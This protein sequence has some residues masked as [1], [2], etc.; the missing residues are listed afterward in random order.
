MRHGVE[1]SLEPVRLALLADAETE[2]AQIIG[3]A[4]RDAEEFEVKAARECDA[5]VAKA[6]R[7]SELA[8]EAHAERVL[9]R[10]RNGSRAVVLQEQEKLRRQLIEQVRAAALDARGDPHYPALLDRWEAMAREQLGS[11]VVIERDPD[12]NG[13]VIAV[14]GSR[15]VD[16]T[17]PALADRAL[18][19]IADEVT[20]LWT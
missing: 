6:R 1:R 11:A 14:A 17:L 8:G 20:Q 12:P 9:A 15:R 10:A 4:R 3:E 13:G 2:A 19:R 18:D 5:E 16:Y 7:R